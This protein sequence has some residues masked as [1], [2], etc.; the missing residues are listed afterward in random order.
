MY[1]ITIIGNYW[2][3][4]FQDYVNNLASIKQVDGE[5][6]LVLKKKYFPEYQPAEY[7]KPPPA[8]QFK[9]FYT[10]NPDHL[11]PGYNAGGRAASPSLM[12]EVM[13]GFSTVSRS[14]HQPTSLQTNKAAYTHTFLM[15]SEYVKEVCNGVY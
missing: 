12:D 6:Y 9:E 4:A 15:K 11:Q 2:K 13:A 8:N 5:K 14:Y 7:N 10:N 1:L 3:I